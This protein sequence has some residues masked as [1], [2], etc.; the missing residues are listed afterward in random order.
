MCASIEDLRTCF[1]GGGGREGGSMLDH[2]LLSWGTVE[3]NFLNIPGIFSQMYR[4][5]GPS[6]MG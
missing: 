5:I 4:T 6:H 2:N 3:K 1:L